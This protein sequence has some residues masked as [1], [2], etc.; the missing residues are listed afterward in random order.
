MAAGRLSWLTQVAILDGFAKLL[1][2]APGPSPASTAASLKKS[3][4]LIIR[5]RGHYST[6]GDESSKLFPWWP[7]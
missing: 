6:L 2:A 5:A 1:R 3:R 4:L 7:R